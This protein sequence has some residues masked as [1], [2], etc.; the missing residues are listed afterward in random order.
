MI[1]TTEAL[2]YEHPIEELFH[3][4]FEERG[5]DLEHDNIKQTKFAACWTYIYNTLY[6][7]DK[8]TKRRY[9]TNSKLDYND[10][11]N[12]NVVADIFIA[13]C[14]EYN[15]MPS[16]YN[17]GILTG[18]SKD[19]LHMWSIGDSRGSLYYDSQ[20]NQIEDIQE[21]KLNKRGEYD[22]IPTNTYSDLVKKI[23][24]AYTEYYRQNLADTTVGQIT[25]ANNDEEAGLLYAQKEA[26]AKAEA[27]GRPQQKPEEIA[28]RYKA[29]AEIGVNDD[30]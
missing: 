14:R 30:E 2:V 18:I 17:F 7:P 20:G 24:S 21:Y 29:Y 6:K 22:K 1:N 15:I 16:Q 11:D 13:L 23:K 10:I 12:L 8:D 9:N 19:T 28:E 27:W 4:Y 3:R 5:I 26:K 25:I